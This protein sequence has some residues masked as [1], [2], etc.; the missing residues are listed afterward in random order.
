MNILNLSLNAAGLIMQFK[1]VSIWTNDKNN[2]R[3]VLCTPWGDSRLGGNKV[4]K[5]IG[6][7]L[8]L[9]A[10]IMKARIEDTSQLMKYPC[11]DGIEVT[12]HQVQNPIRISLELTMPVYFYGPIIKELKKYKE[13]GT[14]LSVHVHDKGTGAIAAAAEFMGGKEGIYNNMVVKDIPHD[15]TP[16]R[17]DRITYSITM[18]Q[19]LL[20]QN[21]AAISGS[22][23]AQPSDSSTESTG[24]KTPE[25]MPG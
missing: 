16:E 14:F 17:A 21:L 20:R 24:N 11:E 22:M 25:T 13:E 15:E 12:N 19:C 8:G 23:A 6:N 7:A 1:N 2:P 9:N 5:G 3:E 10:V 4:L 18:E